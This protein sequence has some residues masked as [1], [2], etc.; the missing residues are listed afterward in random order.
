MEQNLLRQDIFEREK[1]LTKLLSR[2]NESYAKIELLDGGHGK[3]IVYV[4]GT[5]YPTH[6]MMSL[7]DG[8]DTWNFNGMLYT[9]SF[10]NFVL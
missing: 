10:K 6:F 5:W 1:A 8:Q 7:L 4:K 3:Q 2:E 9:H